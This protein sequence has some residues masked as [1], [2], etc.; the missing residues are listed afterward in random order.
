MANLGFKVAKKSQNGLRMEKKR[1]EVVSGLKSVKDELKL[2]LHNLE[3]PNPLWFERKYKSMTC[4]GGQNVSF[5]PESPS[6][7]NLTLVQ[8]SLIIP[9]L[10]PQQTGCRC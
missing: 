6:Q 3:E 7:L 8:M 1:G 2:V 10:H 5:A 4:Y 9:D